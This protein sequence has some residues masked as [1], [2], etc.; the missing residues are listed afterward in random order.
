VRRRRQFPTIGA[1]RVVRYIELMGD[2]SVLENWMAEAIKGLCA[3]MRHS[4]KC[5]LQRKR[6][7]LNVEG[8]SRHFVLALRCRPAGKEKAPVPRRSGALPGCERT[9][10]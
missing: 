5:R 8:G 3:K 10:A 9:T 2:A 1:S 4:G 6:L 7:A